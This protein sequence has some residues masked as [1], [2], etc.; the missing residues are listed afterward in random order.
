MRL[1]LGQDIGTPTG[2]RL[3][4]LGVAAGAFGIGALVVF[5]ALLLLR[6]FQDQ[7]IL[8][9]AVALQWSATIAL[10]GFLTYL[11]RQGV[12]LFRGRA[13]L[14]FWLLVLLLH[15]V[16][17]TP[18]TL[19]D[20][21]HTDLLLALPAS[22]IVS[23]VLTLTALASLSGALLQRQSSPTWRRGDR[24]GPPIPEP[25]FHPRLYAR[26]PPPARIG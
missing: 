17:G 19:L 22:W 11:R 9:P 23:L 5:H 24:R 8:E 15:L 2:L 18:S 16:P 7:S 6:R 14:A 1:G 12:S 21:E 20:W 13:A 26:P 10:L 4:R 25:G 3:R